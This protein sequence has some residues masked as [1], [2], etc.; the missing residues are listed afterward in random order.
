MALC[1]NCNTE[2]LDGDQFCHHCGAKIPEVSAI[3]PAPADEPTA[4]VTKE[5]VFCP[6][7]GKEITTE[8]AFCQ[9]CGASTAMIPGVA[10]P[11][12]IPE[13]PR[14]G[15]KPKPVLLL[16]GI[17]AAVLVALAV[18]LFLI[19]GGK[20]K[21][22]YAVYLKDDEI[23]FSKLKGISRPWQITDN[24]NETPSSASYFYGRTNYN[25]VVTSKD[26]KYIFYPNEFRQDSY[27]THSFQ[28]CYKKTGSAGAAEITIDSDVSSYKVNDSATIVTYI[29]DN[30]LYQY[31]MRK[32]DS[33]KIAS[34]IRSFRVSEDG[35]NLL[36]YDAEGN[37]CIKYGNKSAEKII[38]ENGYIQH[39][40][41]DFKTVYFSEKGV[42]YKCVNGKAPVELLSDFQHIIKIY[43]SGEIYFTTRQYDST[44]LADY[45]TDDV[46][47]DPAYDRLRDY[48]QQETID[49]SFC[50][51]YFDGK[52]ETVLNDRLINDTFRYAAEAP[53]IAYRAYNQDAAKKVKLSQITNSEFTETAV[54][55]ALS[56]SAELCIAT[57]AVA[58]VVEVEDTTRNIMINSSGTD[59]YYIEDEVLYHISIKKNKVGKPTKYA[60]DVDSYYCFLISDDQI[61]YFKDMNIRGGTGELY[62]NK[63]KVASDVY[64]PSLTVYENSNSIYFYTDID[65]NYGM[66]IG[67]LNVFQ[68][69]KV[70]KIAPDV[71]LYTVTPNG[72]VLYLRD[73][74]AKDE[75]GTLYQWKNGRSKEIDTGVSYLIPV[76]QVKI[77]FP[78]YGFPS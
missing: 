64:A 38:G 11:A 28:L 52:K 23:Y 8:F 50:L 16:G 42:L 13:I 74:R 48:I 19:F 9:H 76:Q 39:I 70:H 67:A 72:Q 37:I 14:V 54:R 30:S 22:N 27:V 73:F 29:K 17:G 71:Y 6:Q 58:S 31:S 1:P 15:K 53:V 25:F 36:Y 43:D 44:K 55:N 61:V 56:E 77:D 45:V 20:P 41:E 60:S 69:G 35:K 51:C 68:N 26:G 75:T 4:A 63:K 59:G 49:Y 66:P 40:T 78:I 3:P 62:V 7:C 5:T 32:K 46:A 34:D 18:V 24:L 21:N 2:A 12:P 65:S 47:D 57:G 33:D 10:V